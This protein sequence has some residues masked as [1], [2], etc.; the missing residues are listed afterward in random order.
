MNNKKKSVIINFIFPMTEI[1][2]VSPAQKKTLY[3]SQ[4]IFCRESSLHF[5]LLQVHVQLLPTHSNCMTDNMCKLQSIKEGL[6]DT[7]VYWRLRQEQRR[8]QVIKC[9]SVI[10][11]FARKI[12][13]KERVNGENGSTK[14][15]PFYFISK[16][17]LILRQ[18]YDYSK[19]IDKQ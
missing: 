12:N 17:L 5:P 8:W 13:K 7:L 16:F 9:K 18:H 11:T 6:F 15:N 14:I 2:L 3:H 4:I 1:T 10:V 19:C